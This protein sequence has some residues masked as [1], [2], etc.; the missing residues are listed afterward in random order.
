MTMTQKLAGGIA[1]LGTV[2]LLYTL[3]SELGVRAQ[4]DVREY[5]IVRVE[6][7]KSSHP[8][9]INRA[10][11][12]ARRADGARV[13]GEV[14]DSRRFLILPAQR[15]RVEVDDRLRAMTTIPLP[16]I[17]IP[18]AHDSNC[19]VS[20]V[21]P[22]VKPRVTGGENVLGVETVAV[23]TEQT[24][25][26]ET[27]VRTQWSAP[28]LN[29]AVVKVVEDRLDADGKAIGHF[30]ILPEKITVGPPVAELF[31]VP[32]SYAEKLPSEL[33]LAQLANR[34]ADMTRAPQ[35][36]RDR[37]AKRDQQYLA[38]RRAAGLK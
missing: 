10:V 36:L 17:P 23:R 12:E 20:E 28:D 22:D 15:I 34:G 38:S 9:V 27:L 31:T 1:G 2:I 11:F 21:L 24:L 33:Y 18:R 6:T 29:C 3:R 14:G 32:P 26:A 35:G 4:S 37:L 8:P 5:T 16:A 19:G 30:E 7:S 25:G 13:T